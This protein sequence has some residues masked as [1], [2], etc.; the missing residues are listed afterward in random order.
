M[1][2]MRTSPSDRMAVARR[3]PI[4]LYLVRSAVVASLGGLLFGFETAVIS[5]TT[6]WLRSH[7]ALN[8]FMLGF[9]VSSALIGTIVSGCTTIRSNLSSIHP[10]PTK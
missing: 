6:E 10:L 5:G 4:T 8:D 7:F 1:L 2:S 3:I 9:A